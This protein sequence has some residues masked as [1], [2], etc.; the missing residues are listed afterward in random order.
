MSFKSVLDKLGTD[1]KDVFSFLGSAK[2]QAVVTAGEEIIETIVPGSAGAITLFNNWFTEILKT[3]ALAT[4]A[5]AQTG[6]NAQKAALVLAAIGPQAVQFAQVNGLP[7][8]TAA[9][10]DTV[11][12]LLVQAFN[13]FTV[14][15][16]TPAA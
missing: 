13:S 2:G 11:N 8:P 5:G 7:A 10:I 3:Q 9:T 1:I 6:S 4:A 12:S 15:P 16:S 14:A